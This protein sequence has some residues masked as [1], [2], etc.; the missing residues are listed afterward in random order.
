MLRMVDSEEEGRS[1]KI[2]RTLSINFPQLTSADIH[3]VSF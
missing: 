1:V 2:I 3:A